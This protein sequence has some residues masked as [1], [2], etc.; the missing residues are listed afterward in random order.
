[1]KRP[2]FSLRTLL[3][4]SVKNDGKMYQLYKINDVNVQSLS[5]DFD[6][7]I[8]WCFDKSGVKIEQYKV[9][10]ITSFNK[11]EIYLLL[12]IRNNAQDI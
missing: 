1:L 11:K 10:M 5:E 12:E 2:S 6:E 7:Y 3:S 4:K 8:P 9:A